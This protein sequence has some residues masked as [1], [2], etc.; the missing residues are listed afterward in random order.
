MA[1]LIADN[2]P[3]LTQPLQGQGEHLLRPG[4]RGMGAGGGRPRLLN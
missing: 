4:P 1:H 3:G 2:H